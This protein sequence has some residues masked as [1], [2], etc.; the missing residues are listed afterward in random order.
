[1][2]HQSA[3]P[4]QRI[5]DNF[6]PVTQ[7]TSQ[8]ILPELIFFREKS[9][10][11]LIRLHRYQ[12]SHPKPFY[13][14]KETLRK[15][16]GTLRRHISEGETLPFL[17]RYYVWITY[18]LDM[19]HFR[20]S[21]LIPRKTGSICKGRRRNRIKA[22]GFWVN[23]IV[24]TLWN[25]FCWSS[26]WMSKSGIKLTAYKTHSVQESCFFITVLVF[27]FLFFLNRK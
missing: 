21:L 27:L 5:P 1:M 8:E 26:T 24:G 15:G 2:N 17:F 22:V 14:Q 23:K 19:F 6:I 16:E 3:I 18:F 4:L 11:W 7:F 20:Q 10:N 13:L 25:L 12:K 9:M